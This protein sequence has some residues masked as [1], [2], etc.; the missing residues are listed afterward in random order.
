MKN[1][2]LHSLTL[3]KGIF[4]IITTIIN[5]VLFIFEILLYILTLRKVDIRIRTS[6]SN[7]CISHLG[8]VLQLEFKII[9]KEEQL[10][11]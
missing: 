8:K 1:L 7:W 9:F 4:F 6:F 3:Y 11:N 5:F 2:K 10:K